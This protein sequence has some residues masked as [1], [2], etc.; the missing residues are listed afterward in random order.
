LLLCAFSFL[1]ARALGPTTWAALGVNGVSFIGRMG[2]GVN[3]WLHT[4]A[5]GSPARASSRWATFDEYLRSQSRA[6][7]LSLLIAV[8]WMACALLPYLRELTT[9]GAG[10]GDGASPPAA[11]E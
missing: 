4:E 7:D 5:I 1:C 11:R 3:V 8:A 9:R 2:L 10:A 6:S